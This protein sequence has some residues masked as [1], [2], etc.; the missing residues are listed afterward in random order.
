MRVLYLVDVGGQ[1][2]LRAAMAGT[3]CL[4][5]ATL[6]AAGTPAQ[7]PV[8][9]G[10]QPALP[11]VN[12]APA[13]PKATKSFHIVLSVKDGNRYIGDVLSTVAPDGAVTIDTVQVMAL[14]KPILNAKSN[15]AVAGAV[16]G[17]KEAPLADF[18]KAG[19]KARYDTAQLQVVLDI[20]A[21][22]RPTQ[23]LQISDLDRQ[24]FGDVATPG[25]VSAYFNLRSSIDYVEHGTTTGLHQ[26]LVLMDGAARALGGVIEGEAQYAPDQKAGKLTRQGTR[27]VYDSES[28]LTR[29]TVGDLRVQTD[30]FQGS[31]DMAGLSVVRLYDQLAPQMNVR[32][33][34][35]RSF[36]LT[37]ASTVQTFVNGL[38]VQQVRL[39]PGTYNAGN[40]PFVEGA[41]DVHLVITND[42][43]T[44]ED[45]NFSVFFD[46][47]LLRPGLSEFGAFAGF[48]SDVSNSSIT[49]RYPKP[50]FTGFFRHGLSDTLTLGTNFQADGKIQLAGLGGLWGSPLGTIGLDL[51][52]SKDRYAGD[53][54][55]L[56]LGF[57]RLFQDTRNFQSQT[58]SFSLELRSKNF[59]TISVSDN[60]PNFDPSKV[61]AN[62][63]YSLQAAATY[64]RSF[65]EYTYAQLDARY[66]KAYAGGEDVGS[67]RGSVGYGLSNALNM[68]LSLQYATGGFQH[69]VSAGVQLT[70]RFDDRSNIRA[71]YESQTNMRRVSYQNSHGRGTGAWSVSGDLEDVPGSVN[72]N[73]SAEYAANRAQLGLA[74]T[75]AYDMHGVGVTDV[76]S[77]ARLGTSI[78]MADGSVGIGRPIFDSF[79]LFKTHETLGDARI[80]VEPSAEGAQAQSDALGPAVL[81][82]MGSH[83]LRT[84]TYD[85]PNAP[86]GYDIGTGSFRAMPPYKSGYRVLV[87]SEYSLMVRGRLLDRS[88]EPIPLLAG[89]AV[90][91]VPNGKIVTLFTS[92]D[93]R[94]IAQGLRP[95][96]WRIEMPAEPP[97]A[98]EIMVE[99]GADSLVSV[100][101]LRPSTG[102][103]K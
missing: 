48:A 7:V 34:G 57:N 32:P 25:S 71:D 102:E 43:G 23:D 50:L 45:L 15:A 67:V 46:R 74:Q 84:V 60:A 95:G 51:A 69:G 91:Q 40:F 11:P 26:P 2:L 76:R 96:R 80:V 12:A 38:P 49:Y 68:T 14:L 18:A 1:G 103:A 88:G 97:V 19:I 44:V 94:F 8:P 81:S 59:T 79:S 29:W 13:V 10:A 78:A 93:G 56:N 63:P 99:K 61:R 37:Q 86:A 54:Y 17:Q 66:A 27:L 101:D 73:G 28:T 72:F 41:N 90:E 100:G 4:A 20:P 39:D 89:R 22:Q 16:G 55:A 64:S 58:I 98:F 36:S 65:G 47:A 33:R 31:R 5:I 85:V 6:S 70:Y 92:R 83:S 62:N 52:G 35:N 9:P 53:G 77:S 3:M 75:V 30:A 42:A 87:G 21:D 24:I 82:D